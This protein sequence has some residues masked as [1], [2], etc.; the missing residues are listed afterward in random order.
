MA[1]YVQKWEFD[2]HPLVTNGHMQTLLGI[3]WPTN[4]APY[5]A[6]QYR[7]ALDDGDQVVLHEDAPVGAT[8]TAPIVLMIHGMA[9]SYRSSYMSRMVGRL[10]DQGYRVFRMDMRGCGAGEGL[11]KIPPHCGCSEDVA[12]VLFHIAELYPETTTSIIGFSM[13]GTLALNMLAE[14]G[15]M[16]IGNLE[17][18]FVISPPLD[19][20]HVEQHFRTFWGRRYNRFFVRRIWPQVLR[21]WQQFPEMAPSPAFKQPKRLRDIDE[22]IV[23]PA[24]GFASAE[25]YYQ[26]T[27]PGPKLPSIK[28]PVTIL[29]SEDDPIV[30]VEPLF[31]SLHSSSIETITTH[32]GGHL[33]FL[34]RRHE[35]ADFR[36]LDWRILDWLAEAQH[37]TVSRVK[38]K[39]LHHP[40]V[41]FAP[42]HAPMHSLQAKP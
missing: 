18:S 39:L 2:P 37:T 23:A 11:A 21:R 10:L 15:N 8:E 38:K 1:Q 16:R 13:G 14:A 20:A 31:D 34:S 12:A 29:Y 6:Q 4:A 32:H 41:K 36:W 22:L 40:H 17:R 24:G 33:G 19:L 30:P 3:R 26:Q 42:S 35:D 7:V 5:Q 28:Q 27:S 25:D 9:G